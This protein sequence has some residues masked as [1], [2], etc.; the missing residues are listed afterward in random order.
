MGNYIVTTDTTADLPESYI[1]ETGLGVM[2]LSYTIDGETYNRS[3]ELPV[4]DFYAKM[5]AGSLPTTAQVNPQ[6][7]KEVFLEQM[8]RSDSD[9]L[10]IAFSSGLSGSCN[11]ARLGAAELAEEYQEHRVVVVI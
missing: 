6:T 3:H 11:S 10:H 5:R 2:S 8:K 7:A 1:E 4:K 9:I